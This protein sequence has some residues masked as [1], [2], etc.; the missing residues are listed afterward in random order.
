MLAPMRCRAAIAAVLACTLLGACG[1]G[2]H[3]GAGKHTARPVSLMLDFSANAVHTGIYV[4]LAHGY[5]R[6]E[7]I[8]LKVL[9]PPSPVD[10]IRYLEQGRVQF[11]ILDIHDLALARERGAQ[12]QGIMAIVERPLAAV[13]AAPQI[14]SPRALAGKTVGVPGDPSDY[15]VLNS[16]VQGAGGDPKRV[17]TIVIGSDAV[18]DLLAGKVAAATAFWNDEGVALRLRHRA[19]RVFRV[20]SF[21]A[22]RYPELV[23]CAKH[24]TLVHD[25]GLGRAVVTA[26]RH[27]YQ[28]AIARPAL[29]AVDLERAVGGLD[30]RL[31]AAQ[32]A[33]LR[34]AF[35]ARSGQPGVLDL[36]TLRAWAAWEARFHLVSRPPDV[37]QMF[38]ARFSR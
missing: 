30:P 7:G 2:S 4:A 9:Q 11:A 15:A 38:D 21:G 37:A 36:P 12:L 1:S 27:G 18:A 23:L 16:I 17:H 6:R 13:V 33:A 10:S 29:A 24:S 8:A 20:D 19:Y 31:V 28:V 3:P 26:L 14:S 22:P 34:P 5:D 32:E 25:P 35:A